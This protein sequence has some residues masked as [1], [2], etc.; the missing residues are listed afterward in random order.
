MAYGA[1]PDIGP[2]VTAITPRMPYGTAVPQAWTHPRRSEL[3]GYPVKY[4]AFS[5]VYLYV[6]READGFDA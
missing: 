5:N 1:L 2:N 6:F 3:P 4:Q